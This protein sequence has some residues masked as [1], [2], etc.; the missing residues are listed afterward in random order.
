MGTTRTFYNIFNRGFSVDELKTGL[1]GM[2]SGIGARTDILK[3]L[4]Q[5]DIPVALMTQLEQ[6]FQSSAEHAVIGFAPSAKMLPFFNVN[7]CEGYTASSK[8]TA[9]LSEQFGTPVLALSVFDSDIMFVSYSD[10]SSDVGY[11]YAKPNIEDLEGFEEYD[12]DVYSTGFPEFLLTMCSEAEH[13]KLREIWESEE[14]LF[15]EDRLYDI[16]QLIGGSIIYDE[17]DMPDGF[18]WIYCY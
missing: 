11:D 6:S 14:Y 15:A 1:L 16:C 9:A 18:E 4:K 7:I 8:D 10:A 17:D 2:R 5:I 3:Q 12:T 13:Q